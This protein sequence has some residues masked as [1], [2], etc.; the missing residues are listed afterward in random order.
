MTARRDPAM[1]AHPVYRSAAPVLIL[2]VVTA[3]HA[4][5]SP[6]RNALMCSLF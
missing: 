2:V 4:S 3:N 6:A 1:T 5:T